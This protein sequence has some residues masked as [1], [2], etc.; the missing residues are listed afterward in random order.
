M[1]DSD[2]KPV[3]DEYL[4]EAHLLEPGQRLHRLVARLFDTYYDDLTESRIIEVER[5]VDTFR[6]THADGT[7][8]E[9]KLDG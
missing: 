9:G 7:R 4:R 5:L 1:A 6:F 8:L 2:L 3:A